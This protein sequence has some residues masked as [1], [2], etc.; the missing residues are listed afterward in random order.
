MKTTFQQIKQSKKITG[1]CEV[2]KKKKSKTITASQT[3]NP[4]NKNPD[5]TPKSY[6]EVVKSVAEDLENEVRG[7]LN[8]FICFTCFDNL[9]W[10]RKWP[11]K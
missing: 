8:D 9:P 2:C 1:V 11:I 6:S 10:P 3:V 7:A 4:F 5:G